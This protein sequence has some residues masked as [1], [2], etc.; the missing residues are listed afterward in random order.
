M[1]V[2]IIEDDPSV[3]F[4][5][6]EVASSASHDVRRAVDGDKGLELFYEFQPDMI[7]S[8]LMLPGI[9]GMEILERVRSKDNDVVFIMLTGYGSEEMAIRALEL[10]ANNYLHKPIRHEALT[11]LLDKYGELIR[12][13]TRKEEVRRMVTRRH[14]EVVMSNRMELVSEIVNMLVEEAAPSLTESERFG[15]Q[16]GL[17]ELIVNAIEHGNLGI[18]FQEKNACLFDSSE[19]YNELLRSRLSDENLAAKRVTIEFRYSAGRLEWLIEDEGEGFDWYSLPNPLS[20]ENQ[21][22]LSG[23]GI[24]LASFQF[25]ELSF[26]GNGNRVRA[27]KK[28]NPQEQA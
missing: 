7:L 24:F 17:Y 15:I 14:T 11:G 13:R 18:S 25:D 1:K 6:E 9:D 12:S 5:L 20:R 22:N 16:L 21:S 28:V 4:F 3:G 27:V 19:K 8:D 23:R 10:R 2:L 26:L